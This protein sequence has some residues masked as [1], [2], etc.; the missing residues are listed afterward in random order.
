VAG[1]DFLEHA[2]ARLLAI[3]LKEAYAAELAPRLGREALRYVRALAPGPLVDT[4]L[5]SRE[6]ADEWPLY[7]EARFGGGPACKALAAWALEQKLKAPTLWHPDVTRN[8]IAEALE[9]A[10]D[11]EEVA[12]WAAE[13]FRAGTFV[14]FDGLRSDRPG[15]PH[16]NFCRP[17]SGWGGSL[18]HFLEGG[19]APFRESTASGT[20]DSRGGDDGAPEEA[21]RALAEVAP[22]M[23]HVAAL[24]RTG[25][26][27]DVR[28]V[29]LVV[30]ALRRVRT[31]VEP[32]EAYRFAVRNVRLLCQGEVGGNHTRTRVVAAA[33]ERVRATNGIRPEA[34]GEG[35]WAELEAELRAHLDA[36]A[37][38]LPLDDQEP[39]D[40]ASA[41][42]LFSRMN[43]AFAAYA[44]AIG[45]QGA[46]LAASVRAR[47]SEG[48]SLWRL[49]A[50]S[51]GP[52]PGCRFAVSLGCSVLLD[53]VLSRLEAPPL[54]PTGVEAQGDRWAVTSVATAM[55]S[56]SF[57]GGGV[58]AP[59]VEVDGQRYATANG[60]PVRA[61]VPKSS[62]LL[63]PT[64][65]PT[66]G[67]LALGFEGEPQD[68]PLPVMIARQT[69]SEIL[70]PVAG[71]AALLFLS[72][73]TLFKPGAMARM[74]L[75]ELARELHPSGPD[76]RHAKR[77]RAR[78]LEGTAEA[79]RQLNALYL[80]LPDGRQTLV[81]GGIL[82]P[83]ARAEAR[84]DAEILVAIAPTFLVGLAKVR[85]AKRA[86]NANFLFNLDGALR[87]PNTNPR[88]L[89]Y[90][91][92]AAADWNAAFDAKTGGRFEPRALRPSTLEQMAIRANSLP[93][94]AVEYLQRQRGRRGAS[95][96]RSST[97]RS[98]LATALGAAEKDVDELHAA[99]LV[100]VDK[101]GRDGYRLSPPGA[102]LEAWEE[103]RK[104]GARPVTRR[105]GRSP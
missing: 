59:T 51:D 22:D 86:Y 71:K 57:G 15:E 4:V 87:L 42:A 94:T 102:Y 34:L 25:R 52:V 69:G 81:F 17:C 48:A 28:A 39:P 41:R 47:P 16:F 18:R 2:R 63:P 21:N 7:S 73:Q 89:R 101:A 46:Q 36:L 1:S 68:E 100:V 54:V 56:W 64:V 99:G 26:W 33:V 88:P 53:V 5:A 78:E 10:T 29:A 32:L 40:E 8:E 43:E 91:L 31:V 96:S 103:T 105:G 70:S 24:F 49:W 35:A 20:G 90:Y 61:F 93:P 62:A 3:G 80:Y 95:A 60:A 104:H 45:P 74:T 14:L 98:A 11:E 58:V 79:L 77:I 37:E 44:E 84:H 83:S 55:A 50:D 30:A 72:T 27:L 9:R 13:R 19:E 75:G 6:L 23:A 97:A 92:R 12:R 65:G 67:V 76:A 38:A 85:E 82:S 66:Q